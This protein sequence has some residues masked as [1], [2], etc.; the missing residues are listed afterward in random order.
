METLC[1]VVGAIL[2]VMV[3]VFIVAAILALPMMLLINYI[4]SEAALIAVFGGSIGFWKAFWL[5]FLA[6]MLFKTSVTTKSD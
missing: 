2:I 1:K 3:L 5:N 4:F 6:G